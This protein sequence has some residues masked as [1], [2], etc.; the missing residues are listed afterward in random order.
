MLAATP[1]APRGKTRT[2][3]LISISDASIGRP[4]PVGRSPAHDRPHQAPDAESVRL[5]LHDASMPVQWGAPPG[6]W[7]TAC[8]CRLVSRMHT[9]RTLLTVFACAALTAIATDAL[10]QSTIKTCSAPIGR[11]FASVP[12]ASRTLAI[13]PLIRLFKSLDKQQFDV[14]A[15]L[16]LKDCGL[17]VERYKAGLTRD[18]NHAVYS[19][20]KSVVSTLAGILLKDQKIP[21]L[22]LP[23]SS[24]MKRP[25]GTKDA[26]W[27]RASTLTVRNVMNMASGF[28]YVHNPTNSPLYD[29]RTNGFNYALSQEIA[30]KPGERF[31]YS[32]ADASITGAV[33]SSAAGDSL[34][35]YARRAL[36][37]PLRMFNHEW[38]FRDA[39]GRYPGGWG[40]RLRPMDMLKLGQ[41]YVQKGEWNGQ[42]LFDPEYASM[43]WARGPSP[44]YGLHW[45]IGRPARAPG[46]ERY[47]AEGLKGQRIYVYPNH[48][49]VV[50][51]VA[52]LPREEER[53]LASATLAAVLESAAKANGAEASVAVKAE[54]ADLVRSGFRGVTRTNQ[55]LQDMP[56]SPLAAPPRR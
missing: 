24:I 20:T 5:A 36:F 9:P 21:G 14:R 29:T 25:V 3:D 55:S 40:L 16:L 34:Y 30:A 19:V 4:L 52:S 8:G 11:D 22:D 15:F 32:D 54:L 50:A 27:E 45:W 53:Q 48:G 56:R 49:I 33:V 38:W 18:E 46:F 7:L 37:D 2:S 10:A 1:R 31:N 44:E 41:L 26:H 35:A 17:V 51:I 42:Q 47:A 28:A 23:V 13:E 39:A 12:A 43:A 6:P